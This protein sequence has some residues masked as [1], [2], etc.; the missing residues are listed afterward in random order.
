MSRDIRY[1]Q[2]GDRNKMYKAVYVNQNKL[3]TDAECMGVFYSTDLEP[4][5]RTVEW[6]NGTQYKVTRLKLETYDYVVDL[7]QDDFVLYGGDGELWLVETI[8]EE[9]IED[10]AKQFK[11]HANKTIIGLRR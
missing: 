11:R 3:T 2:G 7:D 1:P 9:D 8:D 10:N 6:I 4:K 5:K